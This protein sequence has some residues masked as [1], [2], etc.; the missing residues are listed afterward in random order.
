MHLLDVV[1]RDPAPLPWGEGDNIPWHEPEFSARMLQEHLAQDHD[2]ASR[3]SARIDRH[4]EWIHSHLLG[5]AASRILDL[6]C[7][8]GLYSSRLA[9][10]GHRCT[11]IDYSPASIAYARKEAEQHGLAC[12]YH[13]ADLRAAEYG[14]GYDLAMLIF[15]ELNVF[16]PADAERILAKCCAALRPGGVLLLEPH[17]L[18]GVERSGRG[19]AIWWSSSNGLFSPRPHLVLMER[20]WYAQGRT[21]VL[22]Y[23]VVDAASAQVTRYAQTLQGYSEQDYAALLARHGFDHIEILPG[24]IP[25]QPELEPDLCAIVA[26]RSGSS[27]PRSFPANQESQA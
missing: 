13:L 27:S 24:L 17:T 14:A 4:V 21:A 18:A 11:G 7:G 3:R 10:L 12:T 16:R 26:R 2:R 19:P 25:D 6:A 5:G 8:P 15:G 20:V 9:R 1:E 23:Y 22:R